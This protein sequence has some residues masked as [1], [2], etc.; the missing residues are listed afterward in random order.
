MRETPPPPRHV[1]VAVATLRALEEYLGDRPRSDKLAAD[2]HA[3]IVDIL[4]AQ[5]LL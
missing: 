3:R 1:V 5:G 2:L 4:T